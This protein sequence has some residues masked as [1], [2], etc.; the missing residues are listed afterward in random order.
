M[1][2]REGLDAVRG[3]GSPVECARA[4]CRFASSR[5]AVPKLQVTREAHANHRFG[6]LHVSWR[7][8]PLATQCF[9]EGLEGQVQVPG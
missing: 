8:V 6:D 1:E 5:E 3:R 4:L 2:I 7:E 9:L